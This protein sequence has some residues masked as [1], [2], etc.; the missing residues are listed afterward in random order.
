MK[1]YQA[2]PESKLNLSHFD[3]DDT[4]D[5]KKTDKSKEKAKAVTENLI[6]RL[7][8]LQERI[9]ANGNR[10]LRIAVQGM[11][12]SG[13]EV[14]TINV[15]C[16]LCHSVPIVAR[17]AVTKIDES[18]KPIPDPNGLPIVEAP[19]IIGSVPSSHDDFRWTIEH[20]NITDAD[21]KLCA[22]C[23]GQAFC[24]NGVCHNVSHPPDM[25]FAHAEEFKKQ[26]GQICYICHQN[27]VTCSRCH[28]GGIVQNP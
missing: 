3:A 23:H 28:P 10:A 1:N 18:G 14:D 24:N 27:N 21:K 12:A 7:G 17:G 13:K 22:D 15:K 6:G 25:L 20:R 19:V 26:G 2:K 4:G 16:N 5:Y 11:D 8:E 9:Y